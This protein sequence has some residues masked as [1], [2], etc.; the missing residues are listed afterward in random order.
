MD[1]DTY[2]GIQSAI[3]MWNVEKLFG[4][5]N[6]DIYCELM[7]WIQFLLNLVLTARLMWFVS[8]F[9]STSSEKKGQNREV[10]LV[11]K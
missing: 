6:G 2:I 5:S 1:T 3:S 7:S 11:Q 9:C 4:Y 10:G 8:I